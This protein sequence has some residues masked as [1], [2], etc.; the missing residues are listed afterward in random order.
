MHVDSEVS[1]GLIYQ[2]GDQVQVY[3]CAFVPKWHYTGAMQSSPWVLCY[4]R[5]AVI[6]STA[7]RVSAYI[8]PGV[9]R[10]LP[11]SWLSWACQCESP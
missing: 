6:L 4:A 9:F 7:V 3:E 10:F 11:R 2:T 5:Y 1:S 8:H